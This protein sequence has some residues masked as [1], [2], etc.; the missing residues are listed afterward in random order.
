MSINRI[1][2]S[3]VVISSLVSGCGGG[4]ELT[5]TVEG[6]GLVTSSPAGILCGLGNSQCSAKFTQSPVTIT[7]MPRDDGRTSFFRWRGDCT[8]DTPVCSLTKA[9]VVTAE[10]IS[11]DLANEI[12]TKPASVKASAMG[13]TVFLVQWKASQDATTPR[14]NLKYKLYVSTEQ[15]SLFA[16]ANIVATIKGTREEAYSYEL[17]VNALGLLSPGA[18]YHVAII[19]VDDDGYESKASTVSNLELIS[20]ELQ[21]RA[22]VIIQ[23][24]EELGLSAPTKIATGEDIEYVYANVPG[25]INVP[26]GSYV[27]QLV[28]EDGVEYH[29]LLKV[30]AVT[31]G[32]IRTIVAPLIDVMATPYTLSGNSAFDD[33]DRIESE[34]PKQIQVLPAGEPYNPDVDAS[35]G[36]VLE[37][38]SVPPNE[39]QALVPLSTAPCASPENM[40][41]VSL[42]ADAGMKKSL[43]YRIKVFSET[44]CSHPDLCSNSENF[45]RFSADINGAARASINLSGGECYRSEIVKNLTDDNLLDIKLVDKFRLRGAKFRVSSGVRYLLQGQ[46]KS[47][48]ELGDRYSIDQLGFTVDVRSS[49]VDFKMKDPIVKTQPIMQLNGDVEY[50]LE[51]GP[52]VK[53]DIDFK[54]VGLEY[55]GKLSSVVTGQTVVKSLSELNPQEIYVD[56]Y[57]MSLSSNYVHSLSPTVVVVAVESF[58]DVVAYQSEKIPLFSLPDSAGGATA[59]SFQDN[60]MCRITY[61]YKDGTNNPLKA[62]P[63]DH[64]LLFEDSTEVSLGAPVSIKRVDDITEFTYELAQDEL[65]QKYVSRAKNTRYKRIAAGESTI[66][67][68]VVDNTDWS[69]K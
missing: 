58:K 31:S 36:S 29:E 21:L 37:V 67:E 42:S 33:D 15:A 68:T 20:E 26:V 13:S 44:T 11:A 66:G 63:L 46:A 7:A 17:D 10:F 50:S 59:E 12:P 18:S 28:T 54:A 38:Q 64:Y 43:H 51:V 49:G 48:V 27:A 53:M 61:Q 65:Y 52:F 9:S 34:A 45:V 41:K 23:A 62:S 22:D 25:A 57:D 1:V 8:G 47:D 40:G 30:V 4:E 14:E 5:V 6:E 55:E 39:G 56:T 35:T 60:K 32:G 3:L 2:F 69:K 19:A 24:A 16:D